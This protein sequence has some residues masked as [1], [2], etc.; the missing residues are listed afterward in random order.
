MV[1]DHEIVLMNHVMMNVTKNV[2]SYLFV[3]YKLP[4][5]Y[6]HIPLCYFQFYGSH[7]CKTNKIFGI[8]IEYTNLISRILNEDTGNINCE[9]M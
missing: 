7:K 9:M 2:I 8:I 6:D 4:N 1:Q 5:F 3:S